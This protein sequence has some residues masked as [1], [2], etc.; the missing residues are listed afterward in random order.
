VT[1]YAGKLVSVGKPPKQHHI[2]YVVRDILDLTL[3]KTAKVGMCSL[4]GKLFKGRLTLSLSPKWYPTV[5]TLVK[6]SV[7]W[8]SVSYYNTEGSIQSVKLNRAQSIHM[9][10]VSRLVSPLHE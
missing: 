1:L 3:V 4:I 9:A 6:S 5:C 10:G 2:S 7:L 8:K